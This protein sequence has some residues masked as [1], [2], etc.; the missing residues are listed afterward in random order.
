VEQPAD[1]HST[2]DY[3]L[4]RTPRSLGYVL[5]IALLGL[6][7]V[8]TGCQLNY[9]AKSAYA[10]INLLRKRVPVEEAMK[11]PALSPESKR[12]LALAQAARHFA[13]TELGLKPTQNYTTFVQLDGPYVTYVVSA[14]PKNALEHHLWHYPL[15]GSL[16][17]KGFFNPEDAKTEA[18]SLKQEGLDVFVRGVSA[19]STLGWF[20]DP[21]LSSM[22]DYR[23]YELV[24]TIIHETVH[25]TIYIKS[26]ADFN[27]RLA[28]FIGNKGTELFYARTQSQNPAVWDEMKADAHDEVIFGEFISKEL[29]ALEKWYEERKDQAIPEDVRVAR[30][31]EIQERFKSEA[32]PKFQ[33]PTAYSKFETTDLNNARLLTY[34]LYM[35]DLSDFEKVFSKLGRSFP[36][37]LTFCKSLEK[38]DDPK[39][40]LASEAASATAN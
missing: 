39:A 9:L 33:L 26:E 3:R 23:D 35:Q 27:E 4:R 31:K 16:P 32:K 17:Y 2:S 40:A 15:V 38:A 28:S 5:T 22:L 6:L 7:P 29:S 34:R 8:L 10:Q 30:L 20:R 25:A 11:D 18:S 13:E 36:K 21:I 12:K 1:R 24:N 19:Y 14:A 37:M